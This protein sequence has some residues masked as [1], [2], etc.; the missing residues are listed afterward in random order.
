MVAAACAALFAGFV[1]LYA[2]VRG[3]HWHQPWN[4]VIEWVSNATGKSQ[5]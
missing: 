4:L 5:G 1:L 2:G 3:K